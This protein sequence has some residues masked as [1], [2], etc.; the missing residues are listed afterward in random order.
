MT[1]KQKEFE[2]Q[3]ELAEQSGD[4]IRAAYLDG[5]TTGIRFYLNATGFLIED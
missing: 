1:E 2:E 4:E 5:L 3:L